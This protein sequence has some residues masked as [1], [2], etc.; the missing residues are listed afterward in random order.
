MDHLAEKINYPAARLRGS[1]FHLPLGAYTILSAIP[2]IYFH[3]Q[4]ALVNHRDFIL[5]QLML[6]TL[7]L[8]LTQQ[9]RQAKFIPFGKF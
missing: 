5:L 1:L 8:R 9:N 6:N 4:L 2:H 7:L 3:K